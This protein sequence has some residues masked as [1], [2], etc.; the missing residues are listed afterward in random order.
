[1]KHMINQ[2]TIQI[3]SETEKVKK[4]ALSSKHYTPEEARCIL[5]NILAVNSDPQVVFDKLAEEV[6]PKLLNGTEQEKNQAKDEISCRSEEAIM[7]LGLTNHYHLIPTADRQYAALALSMT[8]QIEKD[9]DCKT[10]AEKATAEVI[11]MAYIKMVDSSRMFS[12]WSENKGAL[13]MRDRI[14]Y[15]EV[16]SRQTDRACRQFIAGL[17]ILKQMKQPPLEVT[18]RTKNAFVANNQQINAGSKSYETN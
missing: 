7:A 10:A 11:T 17:A 12:D 16:M 4:I 15:L 18:I 6:I 13:K 3:K 5:E 1:M 8:R 14:G 9:Y 2:T